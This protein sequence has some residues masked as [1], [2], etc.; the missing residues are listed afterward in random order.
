[1]KIKILI[2]ICVLSFTTFAQTPSQLWTSDYDVN[3]FTPREASFSSDSKYFAIGTS[4]GE[5][6]IFDNLKGRLMWNHNKHI[7][8]VL[9]VAFQP[10]GKLLA[11][12]DK[13]GWI[14]FF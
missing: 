5:V 4:K 11:S 3:F 12:A 14:V 7:S 10:N 6:K 9:S 13:N 8:D 2:F 1:M